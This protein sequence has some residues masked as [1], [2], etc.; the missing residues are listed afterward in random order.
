MASSTSLN[1]WKSY[2]IDLHFLKLEDVVLCNWVE[3]V[4]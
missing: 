2:F 1:I 4:E 3:D